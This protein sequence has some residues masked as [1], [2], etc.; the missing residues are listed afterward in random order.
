MKEAVRVLEGYL[1][2]GTTFFTGLETIDS[3]FREEFIKLGI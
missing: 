3:E 2:S 1:D